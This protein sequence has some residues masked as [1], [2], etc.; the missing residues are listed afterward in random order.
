MDNLKEQFK[1]SLQAID[2]VSNNSYLQLM[3]DSV[4]EVS[5]SAQHDDV[6]SD[7]NQALMAV[8]SQQDFALSADATNEF[9]Q[10]LGEAF[11]L[12]SK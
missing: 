6:L 3:T 1:K 8:S 10:I 12:H 2:G 9:A 4:I 7:Y 11:F 5:D